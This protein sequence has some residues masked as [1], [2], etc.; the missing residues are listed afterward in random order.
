LQFFWELTYLRGNV[1]IE[2]ENAYFNHPGYPYPRVRDY[3]W[4][5]RDADGGV[6]QGPHQL[7]TLTNK[8]MRDFTVIA[9]GDSGWRNYGFTGLKCTPTEKNFF[10]TF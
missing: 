2:Y 9:A 7:W 5:T 4:R 1:I 6:L 8:F 3:C 10:R